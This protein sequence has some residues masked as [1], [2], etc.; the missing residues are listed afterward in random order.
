MWHVNKILG[1]DKVIEQQ[2]AREPVRH[3]IHE[4]DIA[5]IR[6]RIVVNGKLKTVQRQTIPGVPFHE[7]E[8]SKILAAFYFF[9]MVLEIDVSALKKSKIKALF[10]KFKSYAQPPDTFVF[11]TEFTDIKEYLDFYVEKCTHKTEQLNVGA[12]YMLLLVMDNFESFKEPIFIEKSVNIVN[13]MM[14]RDETNSNEWSKV[15]SY[16][17]FENLAIGLVKADKEAAVDD[18]Y[19]KLAAGTQGT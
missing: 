18:L 16:F 9:L 4:R 14:A 1:R 15:L 5:Q 7:E 10:N 6:D 13:Y 3:I 12:Y 2:R 19:M 8:K 11:N 17:D